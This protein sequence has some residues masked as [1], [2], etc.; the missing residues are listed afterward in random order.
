M[1]K[2]A[3][4]K[5]ITITGLTINKVTLTLVG[6]TEL[7]LCKKARSFELGE[8]FRQSHPK[9]TKMPDKLQQ[10]Y[11]MWERLITSIHWLNPIVFHDDDN[12]L[13]SEEEWKSYMENNKPC[14][15]GKAFKDSMAEAFKSFGFKEAT[16]KNGTDFV[17]SINISNL[18]P[19]TFAE[20]R[21]DQHLA[22]ANSMG[23][24]NVITQQ[25]EFHGWSCEIEIK[26]LE[27]VLPLE[28]ICEVINASG[29]FIGIGS[30]R[31]EGYGRYHIESIK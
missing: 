7:I 23:N 29:E 26:Y 16:G 5:E 30:R 3:A 19:I 14:V 13:Y 6:D 17:R 11:N 2:K 22:V 31:G 12:S 20:V 27:R 18:N 10:P 21:Y 24:P 1:P 15:L 28:T 9:G 25:N 4:D 8:I